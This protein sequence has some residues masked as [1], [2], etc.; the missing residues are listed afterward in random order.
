M[1]PPMPSPR[2]HAHPGRSGHTNGP[3]CEH[4]KRSTR[5][6]CRPRRS[7]YH[8]HGRR[9]TGPTASCR[10]EPVRGRASPGDQDFFGA[11]FDSVRL[12]PRHFASLDH[13]LQDLPILHRVHGAPEAMVSVRDELLVLYKPAERLEHKLLPFA[14]VVE[15]LPAKQEIPAVD[16]DL[17]SV[18]AA[19]LADPPVGVDISQVV[20][21]WRTDRQEAA[22]LATLPEGRDHMIEVDVRKPVAVIGKEYLLVTKLIADCP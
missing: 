13:V 11:C 9:C 19:E 21:Q 6:S 1:R 7:L 14:H 4:R 20:G 3:Q 10:V 12:P 5:E 16:P 2:E 8:R 15:D 17:R 18:R 22:Y